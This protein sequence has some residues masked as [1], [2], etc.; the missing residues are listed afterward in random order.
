MTVAI[1][2]TGVS[3]RFRLQHQKPFLARE[4]LRMIT[5]R[6]SQ[7]Q[8]HWAL[9]DVSFEVRHG[10]TVGVIGRNG[11][12]KS[13]LLGLIARTMYPTSGTV[14]VNGNVGPLLE[15]GAGFHPDL[16]GLENIYLNGLLLGLSK[17]QIE[18]RM[19]A[20]VDYAEIGKF[21]DTP[22]ATYSTGMRARLGFAVV[23]HVDPEILILDEVL[24]VG[25]QQFQVK[26]RHTLDRFRSEGKTLFFVSHSLSEVKRLCDRALWIEGGTLRATGPASEVIQQYAATVVEAPAGAEAHG[27]RRT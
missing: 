22:I 27:L 14:E 23:A 26:C 3:K 9:R 18:E 2:F 20:I 12:G 17:R 8:E 11:A 13:T 4:L 6:P 7:V 5:Q 1:R 15:L 25:D 19:D 16:T 24:G 21:L 10:E